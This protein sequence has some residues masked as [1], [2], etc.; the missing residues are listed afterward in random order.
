MTRS[1]V[2]ELYEIMG[3][4]LSP[5]FAAENKFSPVSLAAYCRAAI[6]VKKL[7]PLLSRLPV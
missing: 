3:T 5:P 2:G 1:R 4:P 6:G 7:G